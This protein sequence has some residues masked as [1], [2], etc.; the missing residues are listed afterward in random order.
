MNHLC[1]VVL[2]VFCLALVHGSSF[3]QHQQVPVLVNNIGPFSNPSETYKYYSLPFCKPKVTKNEQDFSESLAGD[4]RRTSLYDVR[5]KAGV[6]WQSVCRKTLTQDEI[7]QFIDAIKRH[8]IFEMFVDDLP[9]KGFIGEVEKTTTQ[10][11]SHVHDES[12]VYLFTHLDFSIAFN[13]QSVI[14][15]NLTTDPQQRKKL[16]FG[17][18]IPIEFSYSVSWVPTK[19][20]WIDRMS[21]HQRASFMDQAVEI[22]WLSIVNSLALVVLLMAFLGVILIRILKKDFARYMELDD[23]EFGQD[24]LD[25]SGWKRL[26][27]DVFRPPRNIMLFSAVIGTGAQL[28]VLVIT[29]LL[30][31]MLGTFMPGNR[32]A[33]L[34]AAIFLYAVTAYVAGNVATTVYVQLGGQKWALNSALTASLFAVPFFGTFLVLNSIA[35]YYGSSSAQPFVNIF[36]TVCLYG[37]VTFPLTVLGSS[38]AK[39]EAGTFDAPC[40]TNRVARE[41]PEQPWY[42]SSP[43][44]MLIA[45]LLPFS[46]IYIELH[47]LFSSVWGH[48][49]YTLYGILTLAFI[50]LLLVSVFVTI[51]LVYFQLSSEDHRWWWNSMLSGVSTGTF[52]FCYAMFYYA[53]RSNMS[54]ILQSAFFHGYMLVI[55]YGFGLMMSSVSWFFA[56]LFVKHIYRTIHID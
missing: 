23:A 38:K 9:V 31:A 8:Y 25:D 4:R 50:L 32:G 44:Q 52:V 46:A 35:W 18:N 39:K 15:V 27:G 10:F 40:K 33:L 51:A 29:L 48:R 13:G 49:I 2:S 6:Q 3:S 42:R 45:G 55:S 21:V 5:F 22:H 11:D 37:L 41:I 19:V 53:F 7:K 26:H 47:Y 12:H 24:E 30:L 28:F 20:A 43:M 34:T 36:V 54:G 16:I 1:Y 17:E 14:A 56:Q